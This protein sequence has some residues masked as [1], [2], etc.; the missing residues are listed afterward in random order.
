MV[1]HRGHDQVLADDVGREDKPRHEDQQPGPAMTGP[2][3]FVDGGVVGQRRSSFCLHDTH[4][5]ARG[6]ACSRALPIGLP[7]L[8]Q[9]P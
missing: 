7:Q 8:S 4:R 1:G 2:G 6:K 9:M 3:S 5:V